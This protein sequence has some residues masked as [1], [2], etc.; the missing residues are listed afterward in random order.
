MVNDLMAATI[1]VAFSGLCVVLTLGFDVWLNR[2]REAKLQRE[3]E[4]WRN[5]DLDE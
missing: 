1:I 5:F 2:R 3:L 4:M